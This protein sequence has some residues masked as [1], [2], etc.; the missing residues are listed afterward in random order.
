VLAE[1]IAHATP[2]SP[3]LLDVIGESAAGGPMP[4]KV[5][6]GSA[7]RIMT[8]ARMP[9][10][11]DAVAPVETTS[12]R[13]GQVAVHVPVEAGTHV[14]PRGEAASMG[15]TVLQKGDRLDPP[16]I[17]VLAAIGASRVPCVRAPRVVVLSTGAELVEPGA[18]V[19]D[20]QIHN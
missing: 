6:P 16:A 1:D 11:A 5:R 2:S 17:G 19:N 4:P 18:P 14:R 20:G 15:P 9:A 13:G 8:G 12:E 10:G 3:V 7:V